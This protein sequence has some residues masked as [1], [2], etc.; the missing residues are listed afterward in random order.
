M[1]EFGLKLED[2]KVA[3]WADKYIDYDKLKEILRLAKNAMKK[4]QK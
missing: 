3:D 1:V 2:N 4:R